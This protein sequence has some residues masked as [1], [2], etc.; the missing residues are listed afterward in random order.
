MRQIVTRLILGVRCFVVGSLCLA[1]P[2]TGQTQENIR[3]SAGFEIKETQQRFPTGT[4]LQAK[5]RDGA[6]RFSVGV[7]RSYNTAQESDP[8]LLTVSFSDG[9]PYPNETAILGPTGLSHGSLYQLNN[10][11]YVQNS[12][13]QSFHRLKAGDAG[14]QSVTTEDIK[15]E[16]CKGNAEFC[17][18]LKG[19][20]RTISFN[21]TYLRS[22]SCASTAGRVIWSAAT[23]RTFKGIASLDLVPAFLSEASLVLSYTALAEKGAG[24]LFCKIRPNRR[25]EEADCTSH[26]YDDK[27]DFPYAIIENGSLITT[28]SSYGAVVRFDSQTKKIGVIRKANTLYEN[29]ETTSYQIYSALGF[30]NGFI[31]GG[32]PISLVAYL[33]GQSIVSDKINS[34]PAAFNY[35][36]IQTLALFDNRIYAGVWPW[37]Q[38]WVLRPET[39]RWELEKRLF[40]HPSMQGLNEFD[41]LNEPYVD[42][43]GSNQLGQRI[44]GMTKA[45]SS[46]YILTSAKD[47]YVTDTM[48][49]AE[50]SAEQMQEYGTL[51]KV[52]KT[53]QLTFEVEGG[54]RAGDNFSFEV[55]DSILRVIRNDTQ[56]TTVPVKISEKF[57]LNGSVSGEGIYGELVGATAKAKTSK[58]NLRCR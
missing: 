25:V 22:R 14:W 56:I 55:T 50:L 35:G 10:E 52:Q 43:I 27:L 3:Y 16:F 42:K 33:T 13:D 53:G 19:C 20:G 21:N 5:D 38:L 8:A 26:S 58:G 47:G 39:L 23:S 31:L 18:A 54:L 37:G 17:E 7:E 51:H 36:E 48:R 29:F 9:N 34:I 6:V 12:F 30:E 11:I 41:T 49:R 40:S 28:F 4:L 32:Y 2:A 24:V 15:N 44:T 46:L 57:C 45:G 1:H